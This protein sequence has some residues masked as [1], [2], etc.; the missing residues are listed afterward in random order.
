MTHVEFQ[1]FSQT[2]H[3]LVP[4]ENYKADLTLLAWTEKR[5]NNLNLTYIH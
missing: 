5:T 4:N 1:V 3:F 2:I